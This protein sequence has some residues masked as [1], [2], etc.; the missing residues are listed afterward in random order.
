MAFTVALVPDS[1]AGGIA[2]ANNTLTSTQD[3]ERVAWV[4]HSR[5]LLFPVIPACFW[6]E[7]S[8]FALVTANQGRKAL[9]SRQKHAGM[10][11]FFFFG[12]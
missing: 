3:D 4:R 1:S 11:S 5:V 2:V 8:D 10:T 9:D 12:P 7:S 6:R